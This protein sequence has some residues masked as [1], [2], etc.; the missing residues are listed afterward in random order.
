LDKILYNKNKIAIIED[1]G[2]L[3]DDVFR[4]GFGKIVFVL[5][6]E[7]KQWEI[8]SSHRKRRKLLTT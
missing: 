6:K 7:R 1:F 4:D 8:T 5:D 2:E 3:L